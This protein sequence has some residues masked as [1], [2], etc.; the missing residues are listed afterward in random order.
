MSV[1]PFRVDLVLRQGSTFDDESA[2][3]DDEAES[4]PTDFT[5]CSARMKIRKSKAAASPVILSLTG[6]TTPPAS[7]P[8]NGIYLSAGAIRLYITDEALA[9]LSHTAFTDLSEGE[10]EDGPF[11]GVYDLE[12]ENADGESFREMEGKIT[13][14]REVTY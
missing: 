5:G 2:R 6:D 3:F 1:E 13:F 12:I 10:S 7:P 14:V 9:A 11:V 4:V 8:A